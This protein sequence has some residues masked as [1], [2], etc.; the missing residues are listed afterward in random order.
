MF[1]YYVDD[2]QNGEMASFIVRENKEFLLFTMG[3]SGRLLFLFFSHAGDVA[4]AMM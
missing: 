3:W 1:K 4:S 2:E